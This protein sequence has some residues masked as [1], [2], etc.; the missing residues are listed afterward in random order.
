MQRAKTI[1]K[2]IGKVGVVGDA[3]GVFEKYQDGY[4]RKPFALSDLTPLS[5]TAKKLGQFHR[6]HNDAAE[7]RG[8]WGDIDHWNELTKDNPRLPPWLK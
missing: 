8:R 1:L 4:D 3:A 7:M 6:T 2:A 5:W